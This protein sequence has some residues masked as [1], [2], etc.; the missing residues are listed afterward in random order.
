MPGLGV[1]KAPRVQLKS[2]LVATDFS[3]VSENPLRHGI[4]VARNYGAK[5]YLAHVVSSLGFTMAGP[6]LW[7]QQL[8]WEETIYGHSNEDC[9]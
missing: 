8:V 4:V 6:D 1:A 9:S 3:A 7:L 2:V 5:L